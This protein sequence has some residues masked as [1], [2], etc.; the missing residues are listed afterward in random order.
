M[1]GFD[2]FEFLFVGGDEVVEFV[3]VDLL[4]EFELVVEAGEMLEVFRTVVAAD[5]L[6]Q[7]VYFP[8]FDL[9]FPDDRQR[10]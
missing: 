4:L 1:V 7:F 5:L 10:E 8:Y 6:Q 3:A 9:Q 2:V